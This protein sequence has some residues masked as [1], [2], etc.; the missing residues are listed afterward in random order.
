MT[1]VQSQNCESHE[2]VK[3]NRDNTSYTTQQPHPRTIIHKVKGQSG[4]APSALNPSFLFTLFQFQ[5][6][7]S[8]PLHFKLLSASALYFFL[9]VRLWLCLYSFFFFNLLF[10]VLS[11]LKSSDQS[12]SGCST[13]HYFAFSLLCLLP[14][15][16]IGHTHNLDLATCWPI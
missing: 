15:T 10:L 3:Q 7:A 1:R 16:A 11:I 14:P 5:A 13:L 9:S 4:K 8:L 6:C 12:F 2:R